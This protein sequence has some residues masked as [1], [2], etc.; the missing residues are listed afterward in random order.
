MRGRNLIRCI[1]SLGLLAIISLGIWNALFP[2]QPRLSSDGSYV[3]VPLVDLKASP[4]SFEEKKI[5][6]WIDVGEVEQLSM[7]GTLIILEIRYSLAFVFLDGN[8][9]AFNR[10]DKLIVRGVSYLTSKGHVLVNEWHKWYGTYELVASFFGA[11]VFVA[12]V[13]ASDR[14]L[15]N[16]I[17]AIT[18]GRRN[19]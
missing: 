3:E 17:R 8:E 12:T 11:L 19:A 7:N 14:R 16:S 6:L 13:L 4:M 1:G 10:R 18:R 9:Q 15:W 5:S 2:Y